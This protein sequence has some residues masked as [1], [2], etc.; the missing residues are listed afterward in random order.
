VVV[1]IVILRTRLFPSCEQAT[2]QLVKFRLQS[3]EIEGPYL[4]LL[5]H[6][7]NKQPPEQEHV[8]LQD[9]L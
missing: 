4:V 9:V 5:Q 3:K 6:L 2:S 7:C 8:M 1:K